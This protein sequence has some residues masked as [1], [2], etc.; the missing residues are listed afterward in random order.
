M[1]KPNISHILML[2]I[3]LTNQS[4][5][6]DLSDIEQNEFYKNCSPS[7]YKSQISM[8]GNEMFITTPFI[9]ESYCNCYCFKLAT[10]SSRNEANLMTKYAATGNIE[11]IQKMPIVTKSSD[12]C[13]KMIVED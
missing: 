4:L 13:L 8:K 10:R 7:C 6:G 5:A 3:S 12:V 1:N 11:Q 2:L 9:L